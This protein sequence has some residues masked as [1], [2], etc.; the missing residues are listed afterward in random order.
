MLLGTSE[1][2]RVGDRRMVCMRFGFIWFRV[3]SGSQ[4]RSFCKPAA[5]KGGLGLSWVLL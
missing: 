2:F 4:A 3:Y 1:D 5:K